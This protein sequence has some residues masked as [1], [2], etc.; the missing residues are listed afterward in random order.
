MTEIIEIIKDNW[1]QISVITF[2]AIMLIY[3]YY[4]GLVRMSSNIVSMIISVVVTKMM[5]P[6]A[7]EW[8]RKNQ[9]I[10]NYINYMV[11]DMLKDNINKVGV[12]SNI[13]HTVGNNSLLNYIFGVGNNEYYLNSDCIY[14]MIGLDK[15]TN[16]I[17]EKVTE[18]ILSVITFIIL[19]ILVTMIVKFLFKILD[20]VANLPVLTVFNRLAGSILGLIESVLYIWIFFIVLNFLPKGELVISAIE[21]INRQNTFLFILKEAN[22]FVRIFEFM[23]R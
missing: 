2:M 1:M 3:G 13:E 12:D 17:A 20:K 10:R 19:L 15:V 7:L 6:Y 18:F 5:R 8:I 9:H 16:A 21:Q 11:Q 4:K 14:D 23:M 22:I